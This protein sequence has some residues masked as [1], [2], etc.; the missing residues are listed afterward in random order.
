[1]TRIL[2]IGIIL[3][4]IGQTLYRWIIQR[5]KRLCKDLMKRYVLIYSTLIALLY[6]SS[7]YQKQVLTSEVNNTPTRATVETS[8]SEAVSQEIHFKDANLEAAV[9]EAINKPQG[10]IYIS[11]VNILT[12]LKAG[13]REINDISGL[14]YFTGLTALLLGGNNIVD[15]SP[16]GALPGLSILSL[17]GN[18][19][20][21]ISPLASVTSLNDLQLGDNLIS[22][23]SP[24]VGLK[25]LKGLDLTANKITDI[26]SLEGLDNLQSLLLNGR[27]DRNQIKDISSLASMKGLNTVFLW[28]N[29]VNDVS[30]LLSLPDLK[31]VFIL[32]GNPLSHDSLDKYIPELK[33]KGVTVM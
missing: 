4:F 32:V 26:S 14:E 8:T 10:T 21:D 28:N 23:L 33:A 31:N 13:N 20:T 1:L 7:C 27:E 29:Q 15:V 16:I 5:N 22:D 9:R 19:I 11:D 3:V 17:G 24:L 6:I 12:L 30:P 25:Q 2:G 18:Q